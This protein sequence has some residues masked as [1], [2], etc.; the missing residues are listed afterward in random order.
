MTRGIGHR[1]RLLEERSAPAGEPHFHSHLIRFITP[2]H[3]VV[4]TLLMQ[5][6]KPSV[7]PHLRES[8]P[9]ADTLRMPRITTDIQ[10]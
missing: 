3:D 8:A 2:E 9:S 6:G 7:W 5:W 1:L 4:R 10:H